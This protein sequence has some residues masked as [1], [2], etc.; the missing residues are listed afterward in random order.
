[1]GAS[2]IAIAAW[3]T[4]LCLVVSGL[5]AWSLTLDA[6]SASYQLAADHVEFG[7]TIPPPVLARLAQTS[8]D[9]R[10][11]WTC[12]PDIV[13]AAFT[14]TLANIDQQDSGDRA[15]WTGAL[16]AADQILIRA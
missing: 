10:Q 11:A 5:A 15:G 9:E 8:F 1:M 7:D 13:K 3:G 4:G 2:R 12:R 14:L 16:Q 6:R